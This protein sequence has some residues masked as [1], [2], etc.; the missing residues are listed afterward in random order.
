M[1]VLSR[2][3]AEIFACL[4]DTVI[5]PD[6]PMFTIAQ[7]DAVAYFDRLLVVSPAPNR[8]GLRM[9]LRALDVAPRLT[10]RGARFRGLEP[11]ERLAFLRSLDGLAPLRSLVHAITALAQLCYYGN[12][13]VMR[14]LGY[15]VEANLAR[16]RMLRVTEARW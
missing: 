12:D 7:T 10:G 11:A 9:I 13:Q 14:G 1:E 4:A 6:P 16:A 5:A 8:A 2:R 15:D 3:E